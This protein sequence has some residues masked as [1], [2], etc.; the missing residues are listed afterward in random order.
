M[1]GGR[2]TSD[3]LEKHGDPPKGWALGAF[4]GAMGVKRIV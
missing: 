1:E 2:E 4:G 3:Q